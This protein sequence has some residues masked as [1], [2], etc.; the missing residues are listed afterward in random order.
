MGF[1]VRLEEGKPKLLKRFIFACHVAPPPHHWP[2]GGS[3]AQSHGNCS[4][5]ANPYFGNEKQN[6]ILWNPYTTHILL[7]TPYKGRTVAEISASS[8]TS[9]A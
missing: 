1:H 8:E 4:E 3:A 5:L 9:N 7:I 6:H 2:P